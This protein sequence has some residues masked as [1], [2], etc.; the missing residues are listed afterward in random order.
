MRYKLVETLI[1]CVWPNEC[2]GLRNWIYKTHIN[3]QVTS[4]HI[5]VIKTKRILGFGFIQIWSKRR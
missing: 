5:Y 4:K 3:I 1:E 2:G